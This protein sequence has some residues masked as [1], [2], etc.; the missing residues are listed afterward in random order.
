MLHSRATTL[1]QLHG[2]GQL[3]RRALRC[4][5]LALALV[6]YGAVPTA[7]GAESEVESELQEEISAGASTTIDV[8]QRLNA[9]EAVGVLTPRSSNHA[10]APASID[11][12]PHL[13]LGVALPLRL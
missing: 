9:S 7:I 4:V 13:S 10:A 2:L 5:A 3:G 11:A 6:S 8:R 1:T 12:A